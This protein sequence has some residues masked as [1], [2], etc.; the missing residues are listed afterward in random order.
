MMTLEHMKENSV[1][2]KHSCE[3]CKKEFARERT[4]LS[5]LCE[6]KQRWLSKDH[7]SNR[8]GFQCWV[9]FYE[10]HSMSKTKNRTFEE[11]ISSPYY[12]A[13]AKFGTYCVD[14]K[15][16]NIPRYVDWLLTN[17][18]KL[19]VWNKDTNYNK[20]LCEY[21]R[22]ED[23]FDAI[24]RSVEYCT[25]LAEL[26][27]I[28]P[29]DVL[30]YSNPNRVCHGI[31]SGKISPWMLYCSDSGIRF[32]ET[33]NPGQVTMI[34]DYINP[35]QWALKFHRDENLKQQIRDTLRAAGY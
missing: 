4:L 7:P 1:T 14:A 30:R 12:I 6:K 26:S 15:V 21:L 19:D 31:C 18:I 28:Q 24:Y 5:H 20:Y 23:A 10:K 17:Q 27:E 34:T 2:S 32:L 9:R 22:V 25:T 16:I 13:F 29:N 35:E 11:F 3:F 33:L 8:I